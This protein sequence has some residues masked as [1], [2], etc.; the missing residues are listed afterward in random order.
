MNVLIIGANGLIG[1]MI[2]AQLKVA[3][4]VMSTALIRK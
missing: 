1:K 3:S 2:T 4:Y